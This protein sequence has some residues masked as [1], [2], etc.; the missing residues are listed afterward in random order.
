MGGCEYVKRYEMRHEMT[1]LYCTD[2]ET[3]GW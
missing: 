1:M 3:C 2:F